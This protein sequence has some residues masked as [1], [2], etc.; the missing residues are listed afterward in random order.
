MMEM[1]EVEGGIAVFLSEHS[2]DDGILE[3]V[4]EKSPLVVESDHIF[5]TLLTFLLEQC[6]G[7]D[8]GG[9][10]R[11]RYMFRTGYLRGFLKG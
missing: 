10:V 4:V 2:G 9:G 8:L 6:G 7:G 3:F 5:D 11:C 1:I